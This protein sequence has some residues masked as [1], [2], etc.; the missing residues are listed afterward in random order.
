MITIYKGDQ[1]LKVW[2]V[3]LADWLNVGWSTDQKEPKNEDRSQDKRPKITK[4]SR[5]VSKTDV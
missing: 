1:S 5:K 3:D 2:P 4:R